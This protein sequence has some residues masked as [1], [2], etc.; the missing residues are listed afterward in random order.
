MLKM[1]DN[2]KKINK[3]NILLKTKSGQIFHKY[4][5][6]E[7]L[8]DI[9]LNH[10]THWFQELYTRNKNNLN[11]VA[12]YYRGNKITY[13]EMFDKMI[14]YAKSM[15]ELGVEKNSEVPVCLSNTPEL[16][17]ILGAASLIGAKLNI[18]SSNFSEE[19]I[20]E[21]FKNCDK[22]ILFI[23]DNV[24]YPLK[25]IITE[26]GIKKIVMISLRD[27]LKYDTDYFDYFD[28]KTNL[29]DNRV[30]DYKE[31]SD[32]ILSTLDF[33]KVGMHYEKELDAHGNLD[34]D[35]VITYTSGTTNTKRPKA[36]VHAMRS[37]NTIAR[38]HD[39]ELN[40]GFTMKKYTVLSH[41]PSYS[42]SNLIS[43]ISDALMQGA[44]LALEPIHDK[45][46]FINSLIINKPNYVAETKS[47]WVDLAKQI[48]YNEK[49]KSLEMPYLFLAFSCGEVLEINEEKLIN[50]AFQKVKAGV[51]VTHTPFSIVKLSE[52]G[53]DCE[54]G[55][56]F[57]TLFR[58]YGNKKVKNNT[59]GEERGMQPFPFVSV[60]ILDENRDYCSKNQIGRLVANSC[61]TMKRYHN[62]ED[63][64][65]NFFIKDSHGKEWGDLNL[66][67]MI[68]K[69]DKVH[70][71]GR[72]PKQNSLVPNFVLSKRILKDTKNILSCEVV[73]D[74]ESQ[75]YIAHIEMQPNSKDKAVSVLYEADKRLEDI[76]EKNKI[77][78]YYRIRNNQESFPL[79]SS[80]K[81]D[82][83]ALKKEGLTRNCVRPVLYY[84]RIYLDSFKKENPK[85]KSKFNEEK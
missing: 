75:I 3:K 69:D 72:I 58:S 29:F 37:F 46:F 30:Y 19:Y 78:I 31:T 35:F 7:I 14:T 53:G 70:I 45:D 62:N 60:A 48:L 56:I 57:Y 11:D 49:Y 50:K 80:G 47:Y 8:K 16:V 67:G 5:V 15:K 2:I 12:L 28:R 25:E 82:I 10:N 59:F 4:M 83:Q 76:I 23:E 85:Q 17:Y 66:Y 6:D 26:S 1:N 43:C 39:K 9:E 22:H 34:S 42:N 73:Q 38:F 18:F 51:D 84:N 52:A 13:S 41:I 81:R 36:I 21:I 64:T 79:T 77:E 20:Q 74:E 61:C 54:H 32:D 68:T 24:Y 71:L 63:A 44:K 33:E 55:S 40:G 27:S 65:K